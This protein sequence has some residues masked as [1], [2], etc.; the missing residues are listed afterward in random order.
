MFSVKVQGDSSHPINIGYP[1]QIHNPSLFST[2]FI[3]PLSSFFSTSVISFSILPQ[4]IRDTRILQLKYSVTMEQI[5]GMY[6]MRLMY[7]LVR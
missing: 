7:T 3:I 5:L 1:L 2:F 4:V 6:I